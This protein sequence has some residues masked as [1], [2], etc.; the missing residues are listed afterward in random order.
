[1]INGTL[2][3]CSEEEKKDFNGTIFIAFVGRAGFGTAFYGNFVAP[4]K[5]RPSINLTKLSWGIY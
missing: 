3:L 4:M 5:M 1:M 2:E